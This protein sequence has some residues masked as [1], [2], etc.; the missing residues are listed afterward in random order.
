MM[1]NDEFDE[2]FKTIFHNSGTAGIIYEE[3]IVVMAN[4]QCQELFGYESEDMIGKNL[5]DLVFEEDFGIFEQCCES[6]VCSEEAGQNDE[7]R[8]ITRKNKVKNAIIRVSSIPNTSK[9]YI[10]FLDINDQRIVEKTLARSQGNF[11]AI[12]ESAIDGIITVNIEGNIVY[13]NPSFRKIF[14]YSSDE[15][16]GKSVSILMPERFRDGFISKM[17]HFQQTGEHILVGKIFE[18]VGLKKN[19]EEFPFEM[20]ITYWKSGEE[21]YQTSIVRDITA[22][23]GVEKSLKDS[24]ELFKEVFNKVNDIMTLIEID[25]NGR[26]GNFIK[27]NDVAVE[28]LGYTREEFAKMTPKN[29]GSTAPNNRERINELINDGRVTFQRTYF[30]KDGNSLPVE[31]N[32]HIFDFKG[33]KVALSVA[34]DITDREKAE[35]S[36]KESEE[37]LKDLFDNASDL[38]QMIRPDGT[39]LYVNN[40]WK[41]SL[42]YSDDEIEKMTIFDIIHPDHME[43]CQNAFQRVMQGQREDKIET[44][45]L[46]KSGDEIILDGNINAKLDSEGNVIYSRA[47]FRDITERKKSE[48]E[49]ERLVSI[50]KSSGDAI[51]V[52]SLDGTVLD[53]NPAAE[54]IFGYVADEIKGKE[55]SIL[56]KPEK[57]EENLKNIENIK[58]GESVSHFE[59]TRIRK[60]GQEFDVSIT[61]SPVRDIDG[62]IIGISTI[63][64]DITEA[65]KADDALKASEEKYRRIVEKFIQN[66]LAL[67][68]EINKV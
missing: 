56:M 45:F 28:K 68:G 52:Y 4:D 33:K 39:F 6:G 41:E 34:R 15:I 5:F 61:L 62:E 13:S 18:S 53:W 24:E 40:S 44:G 30:T 7:I 12:T 26:A 46:T 20:S 22:R 38:I 2:Y 31:I 17:T 51:V 11:N 55:V 8:I 1:D 37:R 16:L 57:W 54:Q 19:G 29:I 47:I 25:V 59:T 9:C 50:V 48:V 35:K 67:I 66:A 42:G 60:D 63:A 21:K 10:S 43:Q 58:N 3:K 49:I 14:G 36:L 23:K 65:K 27:V 32:S 64:R